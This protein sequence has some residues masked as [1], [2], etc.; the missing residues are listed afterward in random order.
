MLEKTKRLNLLFDFYQVLLT[1]KQREYMKMYYVEDFALVEIA[2]LTNVSRQAVYDNIK[3]TE[4][5][6]ESYES[7]LLLYEKF[8]R[9]QKL[10]SELKIECS[11]MEP[12]QTIKTLINSLINLS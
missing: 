12:N 5:V 6:L 9:R 4:H 11:K 10:L 2:E 7:N 8:E 1:P 3:R